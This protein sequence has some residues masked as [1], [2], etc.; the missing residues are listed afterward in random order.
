MSDDDTGDYQQYPLPQ[1]MSGHNTDSSLLIQL[2]V[3]SIIESVKHVL[4]CET[5]IQ[6]NNGAWVWKR[7]A[8]IQPLINEKGMYTVLGF[9]EPRLTKIFQLSIHDEEI[10]NNITLSVSSNVTASICDNWDEFNIKDYSS[11]R[12]IIE[13]VTDTVYSTLRKSKDGEYLKFLKGTHTVAEVNQ[14][15]VQTNAPEK[16]RLLDRVLNRK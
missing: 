16:N 9:L 2:E 5:A 13:L 1:R 8:G 15:S 12:L 11:A 14:R 7:A 4:Q 3:R 6:Q 10:I